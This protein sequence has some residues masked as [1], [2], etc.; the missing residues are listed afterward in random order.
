MFEFKIS[1]CL[2]MLQFRKI[3]PLI[4]GPS[5]ILVKVVSQC[6]IAKPDISA[7]ASIASKITETQTSTHTR[8]RLAGH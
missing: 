2:K 3:A 7:P 8:T 1:N 6:T 4:Y 5:I